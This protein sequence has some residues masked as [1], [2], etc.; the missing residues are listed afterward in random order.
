MTNATLL[1]STILV[2]QMKYK[3]EEIQFCAKCSIF[4]DEMLIT[5]HFGAKLDFISE[6]LKQTFVN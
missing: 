5:K 3:I 6:S 2:S 4:G 1:Y